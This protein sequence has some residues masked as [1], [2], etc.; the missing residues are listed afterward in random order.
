VKPLTRGL[1]IALLHVALVA[2]IGG[3]LLYDR[4]TRP[5]VW[6][7]AR[8]FDPDLPIRGRYLSLQLI[9]DTEGF[10][11]PR[12]RG[13]LWQLGGEG[14]RRARLE[15]RGNKLVAVHDED[16]EYTIWF[17][18]APG[19]TVPPHPPAPAPECDVKPTE[20]E[21]VACRSQQKPV[22]ESKL[23][24]DFPIVAV[25]SDSV[26]YFIPE[27]AQDPTPRRNAAELWA[28]VTIPRK[29]PPR[30]IQLALKK[31]GVW[32]PLDLR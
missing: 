12:L 11:L 24:V 26:L 7:E 32:T 25:L 9:V 30:P 23:P 6:A 19:V 18:P 16:G 17:A 15:V 28:E 4:H 20:P 14:D 5:R 8:P 29:G 10:P 21:R 13:D 27:H 2:S 3:K 1:V 22:D 31:N